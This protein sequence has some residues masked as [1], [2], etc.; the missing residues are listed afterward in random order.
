MSQLSQDRVNALANASTQVSSPSLM[1]VYRYHPIPL[2]SPKPSDIVS[3]YDVTADMENRNVVLLPSTNS[4]I[5]SL[6]M[7]RGSPLSRS[8]PYMV[9]RT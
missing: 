3:F 6:P 7:E 4:V 2:W 9:P 1:D 8:V 5:A